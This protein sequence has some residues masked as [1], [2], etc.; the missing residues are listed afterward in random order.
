MSF[1]LFIPWFELSIAITSSSS[2]NNS[3]S[4]SVNQTSTLPLP[5]PTLLAIGLTSSVDGILIPNV[6]L[7]NS[8]LRICI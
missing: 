2:F 1:M 4:G 6:V 5:T 8:N 7:K 3:A